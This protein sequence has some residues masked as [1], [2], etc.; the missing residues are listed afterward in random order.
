LGYRETYFGYRR[1]PVFNGRCD[2]MKLNDAKESRRL[3]SVEREKADE[4]P[5]GKKKEEHRR[6]AKADEDSAR[7][8]GWRRSN[9][10]KPT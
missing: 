2:S 1:Y 7:S 8:S 5:E 4:L 10:H 3:G 9:L 6:R